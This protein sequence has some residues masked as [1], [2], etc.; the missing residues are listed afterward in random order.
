MCRLAAAFV[1][2][3]YGAKSSKRKAFNPMLG[4]TYEMVTEN[5]RFL[6]EKTQH[7][8]KQQSC[9]HMEGRGYKLWAYAFAK[10]KF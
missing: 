8:P 3:F 10:P 5:Y 4:E 9:F 6:S 1:A 7:E 2:P